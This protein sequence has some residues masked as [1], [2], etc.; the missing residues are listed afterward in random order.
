[1][2]RVLCD[3]VLTVRMRVR[4]ALAHVAVPVSRLTTITINRTVFPA[5]KPLPRGAVSY[6]GRYHYSLG[7][8]AYNIFNI[9]LLNIP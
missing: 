8:F 9:F 3:G 5:A 6:P 1:M 7:Y 4:F 2:K